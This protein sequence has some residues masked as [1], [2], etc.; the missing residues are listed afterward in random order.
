MGILPLLH[1]LQLGRVGEQGRGG[2]HLF[3]RH[4]QG[5]ARRPNS[6]SSSSTMESSSPTSGAGA[7]VASGALEG[8]AVGA[9]VGVGAGVAVSWGAAVAAGG[10]GAL[11]RG[12]LLLAAGQRPSLEAPV[13]A[14]DRQSVSYDPSFFL[15]H[16]TRA[17]GKMTR[18]REAFASRK[19]KMPTPLGEHFGYPEN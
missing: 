19:T 16:C 7:G 3:Q 18:K 1:Q 14:T 9:A 10:R 12:F 2:L 8:A 5:Q 17:G 13:S 6:P 4:A 15:S 11:R